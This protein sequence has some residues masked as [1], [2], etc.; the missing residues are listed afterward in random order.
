MQQLRT[1]HHRK[2]QLK[3]LLDFVE[4]ET[5]LADDPLF[6]KEAMN[7]QIS[8]AT[9]DGKP[10]SVKAFTSILQCP[11]GSR[12]VLCIPGIRFERKKEAY[13]KK[14]RTNIMRK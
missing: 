3:D 12:Y 11:Y 6:S 7:H 14:P 8:P 13:S 5:D 10:R 1:N 2:P 9:K 4:N